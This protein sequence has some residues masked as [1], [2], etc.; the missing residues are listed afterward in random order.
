[1]SYYIES[2]VKIL[3]DTDHSDVFFQKAQKLNVDI[4]Q[5]DTVVLCHGHRIMEMA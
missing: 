5:V 4:N 3:F 1:L 2:D